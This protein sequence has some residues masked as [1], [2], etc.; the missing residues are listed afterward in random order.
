MLFNLKIKC[1]EIPGVNFLFKKANSIIYSFI[2]IVQNSKG[3]KEFSVKIRS[4]SHLPSLPLMRPL[5]VS[6]V[7]AL[8]E[9][10]H[11]YT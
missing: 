4:V 6:C 5:L 10:R 8:P 9:T 1:S 2:H 11:A 3:T 7:S